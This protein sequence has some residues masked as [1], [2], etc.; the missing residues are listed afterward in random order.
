MVIQ[1]VCLEQ[2]ISRLVQLHGIRSFHA[3]F[4]LFSQCFYICVIST[5]AS[6]YSVVIWYAIDDTYISVEIGHLNVFFSYRSA[7]TVTE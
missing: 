4:H 6:N 5:K 2:N 1:K 3:Q 7:D